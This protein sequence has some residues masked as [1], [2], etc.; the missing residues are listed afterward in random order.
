MKHRDNKVK[1]K[2]VGTDINT[3]DIMVFQDAKL[4]GFLRKENHMESLLPGTS[5]N[6]Y[7][8]VDAGP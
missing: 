4:V 7:L 8:G 6:A 1:K 3:M 5:F 2:N